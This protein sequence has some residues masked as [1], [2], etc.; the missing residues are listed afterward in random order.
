MNEEEEQSYLVMMPVY[1]WVKA[2][3]LA[4]ARHN[5]G[6]ITSGLSG[7]PE[8]DARALEITVWDARGEQLFPK[9]IKEE[10]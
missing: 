6:I 3:N 9:T 7:L 8:L 5:A 2:Y 4:E 10:T 1:T